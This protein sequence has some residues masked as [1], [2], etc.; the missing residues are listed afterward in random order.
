[1][2][3]GSILVCATALLQTPIVPPVPDPR[4]P[5]PTVWKDPG[6]GKFLWIQSPNFG[7]RP[8]GAVVDTIV[9]HSTDISTLESTTKWFCDTKS[10]VSAHFTIGKDGSVIQHIS[11]FDRAWHA[12]VSTDAMGHGNVNDY[13]I[14]IELVNRDDGKDPYPDAQ[15][16]VLGYLIDEMK[17]RFPIKQIVSHEFIAIPRGRKVD[18]AGF[19]WEKLR[20]LG[21]PMYY[22]QNPATPATTP[23]K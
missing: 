9:V 6:Y 10:Q 3:L 14:G 7:K 19:P 11:T 5:L 4:T 12:G 23:A 15:V 20:W 21:L 16:E 18:P 17:R 2:V 13:S 1:M 8:K 22:G